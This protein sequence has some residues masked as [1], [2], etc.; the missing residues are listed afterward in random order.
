MVTWT[1]IYGFVLLSLTLIVA[2]PVNGQRLCE[3]LVEKALEKAGE[4]CGELDGSQACYG[5][6]NLAPT[7]YET[8][9][10][11]A[12]RVEGSTIE[13]PPIHTINGTGFDAEEDEWGIGYLQIAEDSAGAFDDGEFI[14]VILMGDVTLENNVEPDSNEAT[15]FE[16]IF[17]TTGDESDC[18]EA[19]NDILI[20]S[21]QGTQIEMVIN[22]I[23][24]VMGSSVVYGWGEADGQEFMYVTVLDGRAYP[25]DADELEVGLRETR[26]VLFEEDEEPVIDPET[27]APVL[28]ENGNPVMRRY[29]GTEW[30]DAVELTDE[31]GG[32]WTVGYYETFEKIPESL[33]NYPIDLEAEDEPCECELDEVAEC[34]I[35]TGGEVSITVANY[36][37]APV[38]VVWL[39]FACEPEY[40]T[41]LNPGET[42]LFDTTIGHEWG[43]GI[44]EELV[45]EFTVEGSGTYS[46]P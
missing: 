19:V 9:D 42:E 30:S 2:I 7:F 6:D 44:D 10:G 39:N 25:N 3:A 12:L 34:S 35:A 20:Q 38:D 26:I 27:G 36:S 33:L 46:Y 14:R 4:N 23:P 29:L 28:D 41:T 15:P 17:M 13:L 11:N 45:S 8:V 5:Y 1:R 37:D 43:F 22:G 18:Q 21:P 40:Y 16:D 24:V 32:F 31:E